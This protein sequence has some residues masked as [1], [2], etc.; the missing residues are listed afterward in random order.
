MGQLDDL[1]V[2]LGKEQS[3]D[4]ASQFA[5]ATTQAATISLWVPLVY[6]WH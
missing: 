5:L 4:F 1:H 3:E 6:I 2:E